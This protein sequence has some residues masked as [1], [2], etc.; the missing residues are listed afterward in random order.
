MPHSVNNLTGEII[1]SAIEVH[2]TLD[3]DFL[4]QHIENRWRE[5]F[6][7]VAYR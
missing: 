6:F 1:G 3:Q 5:N 7:F 4:N 2:R